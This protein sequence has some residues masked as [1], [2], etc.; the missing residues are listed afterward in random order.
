MG[1][2]CPSPRHGGVTGHRWGLG[3]EPDCPL[4]SCFSDQS[5]QA[6]LCGGLN[7]L[8]FFYPQ[9]AAIASYCLPELMFLIPVQTT[10]SEKKLRKAKGYSTVLKLQVTK[11]TNSY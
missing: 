5:Q 10:M 3:K 6:S 1:A 4:L 2:P 9:T 7:S 11:E 8:C